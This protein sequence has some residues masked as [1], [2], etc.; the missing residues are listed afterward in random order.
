[1]HLSTLVR[2][3][4]FAVYAGQ[5]AHSKSLWSI[6]LYTISPQVSCIII[7]EEPEILW[8]PGDVHCQTVF[9]G[10]SNTAVYMNSHSLGLH[11]QDCSKFYHQGQGRSSWSPNPMWEATGRVRVNS[12]QGCGSEKL[13]IFS[14]WSIIHVSLMDSV[15]IKK[16]QSTWSWEEEKEDKGRN[17]EV[18]MGMNYLI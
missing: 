12:L 15:G 6:Q 1:M 11:S 4:S 8:E 9:V 5:W 16:N 7:E 18:K 13:C 3:A 17:G 14:I 10:H 2:E